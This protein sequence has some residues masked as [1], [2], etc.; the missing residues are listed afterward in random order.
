MSDFLYALPFIGV[1]VGFISGFFGIGG[2]TVIVPVMIAFGYDVKTAI[3]ISIMQMLFGAIFGSVM[4]YR[5]GLLRLNNGIYLGLGGLFGA[6]LSGYIVKVAPPIVL[7]CVLLATFVFSIYRLY[8]TPASESLSE[9]GSN[10][11]LFLVGVFVGAIAISIGIGGAVFITP[12][13][14]GFLG[15]DIKQS[16]SMG[17][18]FVVFASFSGFI[19]MSLHGQVAYVEGAL[20]GLGAL[21]GV[22]FGTKTTH[23]T[24]KAALKKW[25]LLLYLVMISLMIRKIFFM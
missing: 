17:L 20:L 9:N 23:K 16:A 14:V 22:Y 21:V 25:F 7:E 10:L 19:S 11:L 3:G 1:A 12:I 4:N 5:A 18:F 13:L 24:D 15:Y 6:S 8:R 2:G